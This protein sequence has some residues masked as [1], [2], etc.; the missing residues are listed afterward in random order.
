LS[1]AHGLVLKSFADLFHHS[2]PP[3]ELLELVKSFAKA[4]LDH[5]ESALPGEIAS[6]LYYLSIAAALVRLDQRITRLS[7]ADLARG[8]Q[9]A[10]EQVWLDDATKEL[11]AKALQKLDGSKGAG[12]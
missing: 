6:A 8:L 2:A 12:A 3:V 10:G 7:D 4:N 9:W 1:D 11:L 5:P